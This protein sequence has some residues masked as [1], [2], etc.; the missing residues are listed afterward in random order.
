MTED[1]TT[2][3]NNLTNNINDDD[4]DED[5]EDYIPPPDN[6]NDNEDGSNSNSGENNESLTNALS[7]T[8]QC[9]VN[10]AFHDLFGTT[11]FET[12]PAPTPTATTTTNNGGLSSSILSKSKSKSKKKKNNKSLSKNKYILSDIFGSTIA[13]QMIN[14]GTSSSKSK[15][16]TI[17][18]S[19]GKR[20]NSNLISSLIKKQKVNDTKETKIHYEY[21]GQTIEMKVNNNH[22]KD[23]TVENYTSIL[24]KNEK[25][26]DDNVHDD[27]MCSTHDSNEDTNIEKQN[28]SSMS[29]SNE[30][31]ISIATNLKT[32]SESSSAVVSTIPQPQPAPSQPQTQPIKSNID[33]VLSKLNNDSTKLSTIHKTNLDWE[34][35]KDISGINNELTTKAQGKDAYLIKQDFLQRV[36][37]RRFEQEKE[38]RNKRRNMNK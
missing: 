4:D 5:D 6:D 15:S 32:P 16:L 11:T 8:K 27:V 19:S 31:N 22:N 2:K 37:L 1:L 36:D 30:G 14:N 12:T 7:Y 34:N 20:K 9:A 24:Y 25:K 13:T 38:E 26:K 29:K 28:E 23:I 18:S 21:A 35:F 33:K 3:H 10:D 17:I